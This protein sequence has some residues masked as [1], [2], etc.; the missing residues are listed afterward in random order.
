VQHGIITEIEVIRK[1][2]ANE[3]NEKFVEYEKI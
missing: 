1:I 2:M 3:I